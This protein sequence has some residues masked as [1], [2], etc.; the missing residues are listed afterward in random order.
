MDGQTDGQTPCDS[1]D[2]A[3]ALRRAIKSEQLF[4]RHYHPLVEGQSVVRVLIVSDN[5]TVHLNL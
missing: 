3:Y 1:R 2:R 4:C 5:V